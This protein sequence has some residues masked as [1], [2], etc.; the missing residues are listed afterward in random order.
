MEGNSLGQTESMAMGLQRSALHSVNASLHRYKLS[1]PLA[2]FPW[3]VLR[4]MDCATKDRDRQA[5]CE[6]EYVE[7]C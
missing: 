2:L 6:I 7:Y 5:R 3:A 1:A 4:S